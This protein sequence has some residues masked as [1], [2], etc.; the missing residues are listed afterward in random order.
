MH[1]C[2]F[3]TMDMLEWREMTKEIGRQSNPHKWL[4]SWKICSAEELETLP[5]GTKPRTSHHRSPGGEGCGKKKHETIFLER[6]R[7]GHHQSGEHWNHFEGDTGETSERWD[8]AHMVFSEHIDTNLNWTGNH[9]ERQHGPRL[10]VYCWLL[11]ELSL[12]RSLSTKISPV[13][14]LKSK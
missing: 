13:S 12:S 14:G 8:G 6:T 3:A 10:T 5:V 9:C 2:E 4:A 1:S 7:K 11:A